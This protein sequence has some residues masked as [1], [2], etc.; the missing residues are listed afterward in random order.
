MYHVSNSGECSW[1][2]FARTIFKEAGESPNLVK[3]I[4]TE[5]YG[6]LAPS[7]RYSVLEH[8]ALMREDV[9]PPD[10]GKMPYRNIYERRVI[11]D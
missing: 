7:P 8:H 1:F 5:G 11:N 2:S 3:P 9:K 4:T 10:I 6:A